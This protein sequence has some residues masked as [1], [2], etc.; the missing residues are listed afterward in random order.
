MEEGVFS[1][2]YGRVGSLMGDHSP[3]FP[4]VGFF[5]KLPR[6]TM[7]FQWNSMKFPWCLKPSFFPQPSR[8]NPLW[9]LPRPGL[10]PQRERSEFWCK[11]RCVLKS[12]KSRP[13]AAAM[14]Y[15]ECATRGGMK[16]I[17]KFLCHDG[18]I[19]ESI[20]FYLVEQWKWWTPFNLFLF[21]WFP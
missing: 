3:C 8:P 14:A 5:R 10:K 1:G 2:W 6:L 7:K 19:L 18:V 17:P 12:L 20:Y 21:S 16:R 15:N 11:K 4:C 13:A 9:D